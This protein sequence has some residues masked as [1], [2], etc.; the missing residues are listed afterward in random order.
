MK[1]KDP[2]RL[3]DV[4]PK[5]VPHH[6]VQWEWNSDHTKVMYEGVRAV[7]VIGKGW[8]FVTDHGRAGLL[9]PYGGIS[10][11]Q[12]QHDTLERNGDKTFMNYVFELPA[13]R[14]KNGVEVT[15]HSL[16]YDGH[17]RRESPEGC[18]SYLGA[19]MNEATEGT[20]KL[21][22]WEFRIIDTHLYKVP[23]YPC[24]D[25][26]QRYVIFAELMVDVRAVNGFIGPARSGTTTAL[27]GGLESFV[28]YGTTDPQAGAI[29]VAKPFSPSSCVPGT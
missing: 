8:G 29:Y 5:K 4:R 7:K 26:L 25:P 2:R 11:T 1:T 19:L 9:V 21:Y 27:P 14:M 17:P 20:G 6:F 22:S 18:Q 10:M 16:W 28:S 15:L 3:Y 24:L 13:K 23:P 12:A